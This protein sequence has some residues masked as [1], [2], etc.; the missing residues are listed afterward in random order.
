[1]RSRLL[2]KISEFE[3]VENIAEPECA[4][5]VVWWKVNSLNPSLDGWMAEGQ[6]GD[7]WLNLISHDQ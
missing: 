4:D 1:L 5:G 6:C 3:T 7:Y 2:G